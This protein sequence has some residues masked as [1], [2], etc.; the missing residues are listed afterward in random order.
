MIIAV[1]IQFSKFDSVLRDF[2]KKIYQCLNHNEEEHHGSVVQIDYCNEITDSKEE[3]LH[4]PVQDTQKF[5][6]ILSQLKLSRQVQ[7][8]QVQNLQL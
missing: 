7:D 8:E 5:L 2:R 3:Y 4:I 6:L 1:S